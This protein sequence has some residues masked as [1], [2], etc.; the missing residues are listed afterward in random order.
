MADVVDNQQRGTGKE[1]DTLV[2]TPFAFGAGE[3]ADQV[4]QVQK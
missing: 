2:Q 4:G 1:P 3:L